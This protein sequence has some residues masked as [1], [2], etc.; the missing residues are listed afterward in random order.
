MDFD[1]VMMLGRIIFSALFIGSGI[2]H[3]ADTEGSTAYAESKG[4]GE[5]SQLLV[6][7]SG[8]CLALGGV[9][10]LFGVWVDLATLLLAVLVLIL[11]FRMH[12]FWNESDEAAKQLEMSMFMKN[13]AIAG[14]AIVLSGAYGGPGGEFLT[15]QLVDPVGLW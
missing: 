14:G 4:L 15:G 2:G 7:I 3:L 12:A 13:L 10:T 8:A 6:Q 9:A 1:T 11:A 5:N